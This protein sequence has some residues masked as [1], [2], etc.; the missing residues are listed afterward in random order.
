[1]RESVSCESSAMDIRIGARDGHVDLGTI[2]PN[3]FGVLKADSTTCGLPDSSAMP[4][5]KPWR[6]ASFWLAGWMA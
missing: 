3:R 6:I 4:R 2:G 5:T 1:M